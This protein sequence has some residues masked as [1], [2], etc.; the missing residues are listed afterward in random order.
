MCGVVM[1]Q[2]AN[3]PCISLI[4]CSLN[5]YSFLEHTI[6]SVLAQGYGQLEYVIVDGGSTDGSVDLIRKYQSSLKW[7]VSEPDRGQSEALM[8]GFRRASG[9]ML[10]WLCSDDLLEPGA[11]E[12]VARAHAENP[13][14][15]IAGDVVM[16]YDDGR[17]ERLLPQRNLAFEPMVKIWEDSSFYSQPGV[18]FPA[19]AFERVGG[20]DLNLRYCMDHDLM[21]R[22][23]RIC[24][25][26]YLRSV[27]ARARVHSACKTS[28]EH[29]KMFIES[30]RVSRRYWRDLEGTSPRLCALKMNG[31]LTWVAA[32]Q[33][34][35]GRPRACFPI[36]KEL[37]SSLVGKV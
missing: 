2:T 19:Q 20:L 10:G 25:V 30:T 7:W 28:A 16:F 18:F 12:L 32:G 14:A 6:Q 23:L 24:P 4:T 34:Y 5:H 35:Y 29:V 27:I 1:T 33:L 15:I 21:N 36:L 17:P 8:K 13:G 37:A 26:V 3:L 31:Y 11:L 22:L 9:E